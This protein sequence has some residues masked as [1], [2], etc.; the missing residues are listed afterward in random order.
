MKIISQCRLSTHK[1]LSLTVSSLTS[2]V[3]N[4]KLIKMHKYWMR[5]SPK[6]TPEYA[7]LIKTGPV[8]NLQKKWP[9]NFIKRMFGNKSATRPVTFWGCTCICWKFI[10][11]VKRIENN[12]CFKLGF[13][14][15]KVLLGCVLYVSESHFVNT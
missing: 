7:L 12:L 4:I 9:K 10:V 14:F 8:E 11:S 5:N 2:P 6:C 3:F 15:N 13:N 1:K